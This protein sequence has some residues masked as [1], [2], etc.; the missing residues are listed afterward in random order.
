MKRG[1]TIIRRA[2]GNKRVKSLI[3]KQGRAST[4]DKKGNKDAVPC[5]QSEDKR[6]G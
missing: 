4:V 1:K 2:R 5:N 6:N 3:G